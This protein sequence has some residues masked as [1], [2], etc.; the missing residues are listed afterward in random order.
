MIAAEAAIIKARGI[1]IGTP[2]RYS[3]SSK[4]R[5][6]LNRYG[7]DNDGKD[8]AESV[9]SQNVLIYWAYTPGDCELQ[10]QA[11]GAGTSAKPSASIGAASVLAIGSAIDATALSAGKLVVGSGFST[12]NFGQ[13]LGSVG[14]GLGI[15]G[16]IAGIITKITDAKIA[17]QN[18]GR[19]TLCAI[20]AQYNALAPS[21]EE[22][23][24]QGQI[25]LAQVR[26]WSSQARDEMLSL[27]SKA[28]PHQVAGWP[29]IVK[30]LTDFNNEVRWPALA[31][32]AIP[33]RTAP[34]QA[35]ASSVSGS[36]IAQ[37]GASLPPANIKASG[38][39]DPNGPKSTSV[40][41]GLAILGA[42]VSGA[43]SGLFRRH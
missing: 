7:R 37:G 4:V 5:S 33:V 18:L 27:L 31:Q 40:A 20:S 14:V 8:F 2:S 34:A 9:L 24:A 30:A 15:F 13:A 43:T 36:Q 19:N 25:T 35:P 3:D 21:V 29:E 12:G 23:L 1:T 38:L 10:M 32:P 26:V 39:L 16:T 28:S 22:A 41:I 42:I 17:A 6:Y 11:A